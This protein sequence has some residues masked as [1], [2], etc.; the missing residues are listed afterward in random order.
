MQDQ[1]PKDAAQSS[2]EFDEATIKRKLGQALKLLVIFCAVYFAGAM[3]AAR[4]FA[5]IGQIQILGMPLAIYTG[6]LVF[7]VGII[8]TYMCLNLDDKE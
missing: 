3:V 1:R 5:A 8:V 4:E 6:L 2:V 7:V